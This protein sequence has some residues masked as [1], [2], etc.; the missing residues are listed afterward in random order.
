MNQL[1]DLRA[2]GC[3]VTAISLSYGS[4]LFTTFTG[5]S[6]T[7]RS[8]FCGRIKRKSRTIMAVPRLP[9]TRWQTAGETPGGTHPILF[10]LARTNGSVRNR[11][12][13]GRS[14]RPEHQFSA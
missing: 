8:R 4:W 13:I 1:A 7:S 10:E 6:P 3:P 2:C 5:D 9:E 11:K 14:A 12:R